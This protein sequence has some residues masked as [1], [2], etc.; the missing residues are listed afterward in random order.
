MM[1]EIAL[2]GPLQVRWQPRLDRPLALHLAPIHARIQVLPSWNTCPPMRSAAKFSRRCRRRI[3]SAIIRPS[4]KWTARRRSLQPYGYDFP[5]LI[6]ET[7]PG[8]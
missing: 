2:E 3:R 4:R 8:V 6:D 7:A 5:R 1:V